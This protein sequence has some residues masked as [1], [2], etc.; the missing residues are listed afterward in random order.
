[1]LTLIPFTPTSEHL[2]R[3]DACHTWLR[4]GQV[5][6]LVQGRDFVPRHYCGNCRISLNDLAETARE[7]L[8][9][10]FVDYL[11]DLGDP[12][13][14]TRATLDKWDRV[15]LYLFDDRYYDL[16]AWGMLIRLAVQDLTCLD[17][18]NE[19][20]IICVYKWADHIVKHVPKGYGV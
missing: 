5:A 9:T 10:S 2:A 8:V 12:D 11:L 14:V 6:S 3:C 13:P 18:D 17:W 7:K 16:M 15:A 4:R 1:M 20:D 19:P